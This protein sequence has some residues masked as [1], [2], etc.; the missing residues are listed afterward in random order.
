MGLVA[1]SLF[2]P[3]CDSKEPLHEG[4]I[5]SG[6]KMFRTILAAETGIEKK[7]DNILFSKLYF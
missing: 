4:R 1:I 7:I 6:L 3:V 5:R 2:I